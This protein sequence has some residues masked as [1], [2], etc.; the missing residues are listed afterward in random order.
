MPRSDDGAVRRAER[1][2]E[3]LR[4]AHER[5]QRLRDGARLVA[6][7]AGARVA[8][9]EMEPGAQFTRDVAVVH[10]AHRATMLDIPA[11][12]LCVGRIDRRPGRRDNS[13]LYIGRVAV[14]D[15]HGDPMIV[16]W[17]A[18]AAAAFYRASAPA[19]RWACAAV[20]TS[21]GAAASWWASTTSSST[22]V[23]STTASCTW[24]ARPPSSPHWR[25]PAPGA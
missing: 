23:P 20:A 12:R 17:R 8:A 15:E 6:E 3:Y 2:R 22:A 19:T 10:A 13:T 18:P 24:W 4:A 11:D 7:Q 14:S 1:E 25:R 16:D 5:V 21:A 9:D